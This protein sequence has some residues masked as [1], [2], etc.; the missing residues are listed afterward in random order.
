M[1]AA[2]ASSSNSSISKLKP[3]K[4]L[5]IWST[6]EKLCLASAV[7]KI[8]DQN[9]LSVSRAIKP[10][11][12]SNRPPEWFHQKNCVQQYYDM[13]EQLEHQ[14]PKKKRGDKSDNDT[15]SL[16]IMRKMTIERSEQLK[17]EVMEMQ[18]EFMKMQ[19]EI[20]EINN[21]Q[22]DTRIEDEW[23][24]IQEDELLSEEGEH[25]QIKVEE[26]DEETKALD[27]ELSDMLN[28]TGDMDD[29]GQFS[30]DEISM[31]DD[32]QQTSS[33]FLTSTPTL[34]P[35]L[36][37][38]VKEV[39]GGP[40]HLLS[41]LLQ[42]QVKNAAGLEKL[43][44]EQEQVE[45]S[46]QNEQP[47]SLKSVG[48]DEQ[49]TMSP[50]SWNLKTGIPSASDCEVMEE[51]VT[52]VTSELTS[53]LTSLVTPGEVVIEESVVED[54]GEIVTEE[55]VSS[56]VKLEENDVASAV[57]EVAKVE[58]IQETVE[59]LTDSLLEEQASVVK[60]EIVKDSHD[61][62]S[63]VFKKTC[64]P[65]ETVF[66]DIKDEPLSPTSSISSRLS[67][68]GS[69]RAG[70][71]KGRPKAIRSPRMS[72]K[73]SCT[74]DGGS[75]RHSDVELSDADVTEADDTMGDHLMASAHG[76]VLSESFPN[77]P[78]TSM[79]SDTEEEKSFKAW[80]KSIMMVWR[81]ASAHKFASVF[82]HPVTDDIAPG[83]SS[84]I[85]RPIDLST[86]KKNI[87]SGHLR[88]TAEF[89][90]DMMLMFTN[91]IMYNS[92]G[93]NVNQ[94]AQVMYD[95]VM[96]HIEMMMQT[97]TD[98]K[99]LRQSRRS[100]AVDH[101]EDDPKKNRDRRQSVDHAEG[102]KTKKRKRID[103]ALS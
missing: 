13:M 25:V 47:K 65:L 86:I 40:S 59:T 12:D 102:G 93:H 101:K 7:Y 42:S 60:E 46:N 30:M 43:K 62:S 6:R 85:K 57:E 77:S 39:A 56:V 75:S 34:T 96:K 21:G 33:Q 17:K 70:R 23:E 35:T 61:E 67:E 81:S 14:Q 26:M 5:D 11:A 73:K 90:R 52:S 45:T 50:S 38:H 18:Q 8:G 28:V 41:S 78:A 71:G 44:R 97:T 95:D 55:V 16:Q 88:T 22:W 58:T 69:K 80:K 54:M 1:A 19:N 68:T 91:A 66:P 89:Q 87:D 27:L 92:S 98:S 99:N 15:A 84:V 79:C 48:D 32:S 64:E 63:S 82:S 24:K 20:E 53:D 76:S 29:T 94:M 49:D 103:D 100:D 2:S 9:W 72:A 74:D 3:K 4:P 51:S 37:P 83:Y 31:D 10:Y 36:T